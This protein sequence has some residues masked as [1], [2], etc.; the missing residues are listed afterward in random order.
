MKKKIIKICHA[1]INRLA[2]SPEDVYPKEACGNIERAFV[3]NGRSFYKFTNAGSTNILRGIATMN[4]Y[5]LS[6]CKIS[7]D[8]LNRISDDGLSAVNK[9]DLGKI[10]VLF[11]FLK[12]RLTWQFD[13]DALYDLAAIIYFDKDENLLDY[14][15]EYAK[16]KIAF[17]KEHG[18]KDFFLQKILPITSESLTIRA[19]DLATYLEGLKAK[20][21]MMA[22]AALTSL[23]N[24]A[25]KAP[26][27]V[28]TDSKSIFLQSQKGTPSK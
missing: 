24:S 5:N 14:D 7:A 9:G 22:T 19:K 17:W 23:K 15:P 8:E 2:E 18:G 12:E 26:T 11:H 10:A 13:P 28:S 6:E 1:I 25:E 27:N 21:S 3:V 4:L 20:K 16:K